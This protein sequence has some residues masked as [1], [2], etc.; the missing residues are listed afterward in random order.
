VSEYCVIYCRV[1]TDEQEKE[2]VSL[3][4]Q[5]SFLKRYAEEKN[6]IPINVFSEGES[7][8]KTERKK[9]DEMLMWTKENGVKILLVEKNDRFHRPRDETTE[10][11]LRKVVNDYGVEE[12][13]FPKDSMVWK[14]D[15]FPSSSKLQ[16]RMLSAVSAYKSDLISEEVIKV[17]N[18]KVKRGIYLHM[19]PIGYEVIPQDRYHDKPRK[20][21]Q[22]EEAPKVKVLLET[23]SAGKFSLK[24]IARLAKDQGLTSLRGQ[25]LKKD[26]ISRLIKSRFYYGEFD[27]KGGV[28]K[29]KTK[30]F[31]PIITKAVWQENQSIL[32]RRAGTKGRDKENAFVYNSLLTCGKCGRVIFGEKWNHTIK[33]K[34]KKGIVERHYEYPVRYHCTKGNYYLAKRGTRIVPADKVDKELLVMKEDVVGEDGVMIKKSNKVEERVCDNAVFWEK[35]IEEEILNHLD[36]LKF[37]K[38][39]WRELK[40]K[41]F[42]DETKEFLDLE[43]K[44]LRQEATNNESRLDGLYADYKKDVIDIEF[45]KTRSA[46]LRARQDEVKERL[47]ELDEERS[48]YD[49][50]VGRAIV[51]IDA[52]KDFRS[53][54]LKASYTDKND[55]LRLMTIKISTMS[56]KRMVEGKEKVYK[57]LNLIWNKEF[58]GLFELGII[59]KSKEY[60]KEWSLNK[61]FNSSQVRDG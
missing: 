48:I 37:N 40:E 53:K 17:L 11:T 56:Y 15:K 20:I 30:G 43:I 26:A 50:S 44:T 57:T 19:P 21:V 46:K 16:Y 28:Y 25:E 42:K 18:E 10:S 24:Q 14:K 36:C 39:R 58:R 54:F 33:D 3:E 61:N 4:V 51:V 22:S 5:E 41:L 55:M 2:G 47:K 8:S 23:F 13:H 7:A 60:R 29:N 38:K 49:D 9:F 45:F 27:W 34:T 1:S 6:L 32:N 35:E 31:M 59:E 52:M 12:V